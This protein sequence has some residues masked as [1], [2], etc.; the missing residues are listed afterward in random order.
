MDRNTVVR[1]V[2]AFA[3]GVLLTFLLASGFN[4]GRYVP[5]GDKGM[6]I[7]DTRTG[8]VYGESNHG[9]HLLVERVGKK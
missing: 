4:N 3:L 2:L 1:L 9:W 8:R 5:F 6:R 7:L